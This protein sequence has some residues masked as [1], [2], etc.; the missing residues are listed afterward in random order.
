M[1]IKKIQYPLLLLILFIQFNCNQNAKQQPGSYKQEFDND[2]ACSVLLNGYLNEQNQ[3]DANIIDTNFVIQKVD[4]N[5]LMPIFKENCTPCHK[6]NGN[7]PFPLTDFKTIRKKSLSIRDV[8]MHRIMPP[9]M[10]D[11]HYSDMMN[12]P[13]INDSLRCCIIK[14]IDAGS[15]PPQLKLAEE[16]EKTITKEKHYDFVTYTAKEH[17][18]NS[19]T[20][21]YQCFIIDL[22][23]ERDTFLKSIKH[24]STNPAAIH[25]IMV[26][27][28]TTSS[29]KGMEN[30]WDCKQK[31]IAANLVPIDAWSKGM[32]PCILTEDFAYRF[33]KGS[34]L[35][36]QIHYGDE[37]NLGKKEKTNIDLFFCPRPQR[38]VKFEILNN[39]D[40]FFPANKVKTET[41]V[42]HTDTAISILGGGPHMHF[43]CKKIEL[44]AITPEKKKINILRINNWDYLWQGNYFYTHPIIIPAGST[45]Y[46]NAVFDNTINNPQQPNNPIKNVK[47]NTYSKEEMMVLSLYITGYRKGDEKIIPYKVLK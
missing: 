34:K 13:R 35:I 26:F 31:E 23:L 39:L 1:E 40:I 10:G 29:T 25:H 11:T 4:F 28:D 20:D 15:P 30:C 17:T 8:L 42:Y 21:S 24:H 33:P 36:L 44:F 46:M 12:A 6:P 14:W 7:G 22:K 38:I 37:G 16:K 43:L 32:L 47:Y 27:L 18:I 5:Q 19:N 9:F 2:S 41:I 3:F 45:V